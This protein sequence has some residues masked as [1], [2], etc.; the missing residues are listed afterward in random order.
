MAHWIETDSSLGAYWK[1]GGN[2]RQPHALLTPKEDGRNHSDFFFNWGMVA[3]DPQLAKRAAVDLGKK[4]DSLSASNFDLINRVVGPGYGAITLADRLA[5]VLGIPG[6]SRVLSGFTEK[7]A[8]GTMIARLV[9]PGDIVL[10]CE[11]T[12]TSGGSVLRSIHALEKI[13]CSVVPAVACVCNRSGLTHIGQYEIVSL[14]SVEAHSWT[15]EE[16]PLCKAGSE[17]IK[18]KT[19][20]ENW[21]RL[22]ATYD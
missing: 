13:G 10:P 19:P 12:I 6:F 17:A 2:P 16:C 4:I 11:D 21:Q 8:D 3:Q 15:A 9:Q 18:P 1:Y 5:E 7:S 20:V 14:F 22:T